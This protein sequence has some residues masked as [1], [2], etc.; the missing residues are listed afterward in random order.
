M[1][2]R[3]KREAI[4]PKPLDDEGER[5]SAASS[6]ALDPNPLGDEDRL[7]RAL[8]PTTLRVRP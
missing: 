4:E 8:R 6:E 5:V 1:A 2:S 7:D 3:K